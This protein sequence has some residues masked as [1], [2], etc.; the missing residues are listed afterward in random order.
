MVITK[1]GHCCLLI[2]VDGVVV[3]TDPGVFTSDVALPPRVDVVVITHEHSDHV[4]VDT[5]LALKSAFPRLSI[6]CNSAVA[7]LLAVAKVLDVVVLEGTA[8][9]T[10]GGV[11][12][13][14]FD[15]SHAEIF[16]EVGKVQNTGY[17]ITRRLFYPGDA[18][19]EPLKPIEVLALP[20]GGP[21]C[22]LTDALHYAL[23]VAPKQVFPVHDAI[24]RLDRI[25]IHHGLSERIL[26]E[27]GIVFTPLLPGHS[28]TL[29]D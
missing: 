15:G 27:R 14:A 10:V 6:V 19:A 8:A 24:E 12:L 22:R 17:F 2:E 25:S 4:H 11:Y 18:Y 1:I 28:L 7:R 23:R 3:M 9:A 20:V 5:V 26:G 16:E 13:E 29:V 21:W